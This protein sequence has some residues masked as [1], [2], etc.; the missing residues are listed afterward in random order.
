M[1]SIPCSISLPPLKKVSMFLNITKFFSLHTNYLASYL[2]K[3]FHAVYS[4]LFFLCSIHFLLL[5]CNLCRSC[6]NLL[7]FLFSWSLLILATRD[8]HHGQRRMDGCSFPSVDG[9]GQH[10]KPSLDSPLSS[11]AWLE[12][13]S[14]LPQRSKAFMFLLLF[15][16]C[17]VIML[18]RSL[19]SFVGH[20]DYMLF[21]FLMAYRISRFTLYSKHAFTGSKLPSFFLSIPH[22]EQ[23]ITLK[24]SS[25][26]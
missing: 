4:D 12:Q 14:S 9:G 8:R 18:F 7:L 16:T 23:L 19:C 6:G 25:A 13:A 1:T 2:L 21:S 17:W 5:C 10:C 3:T 24:H 22:L 20:G 26:P 11:S 15:A